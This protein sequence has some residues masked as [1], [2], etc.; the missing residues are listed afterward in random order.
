MVNPLPSLPSLQ[1]F[2]AVAH[3]GGVRR[4]AEV[5]SLSEAA[6]SHRIKTLEQH[7]GQRLFEKD[8]RGLRLTDLGQRYL[9]MIAGPI[10]ELRRA[11]EAISA[12][13]RARHVT[14]T[15]PPTLASLWLIPALQ[16]FERAL[17]DVSLHLVTTTQCLDLERHDID[18][19]IRYLPEDRVPDDARIVF[20]ET[21]FPVCSPERHRASQSAEGAVDTL[22]RGR[23]LV[24]DIHPD[25]W[26]WWSAAYGKTVDL[27]GERRRF[28]ASHMTL[29]AAAQ[30]YGMAMGRRPMV[31][32]FLS[33]GR[34]V[35]PFGQAFRTGYRYVILTRNGG[36]GSAAQSVIDWLTARFG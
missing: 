36:T 25:E 35:A 19:A 33:T 7:L 32:P 13:R 4:A 26:D 16:D 28:D 29:E 23:L 15:L 2:L 31:D 30:G 14:V 8:G 9:G 1:A 3:R 34:L 20:S 22:L 5:L 12:R 24:N 21:A 11:C 27:T 6:V 10:D 18:L 17:P